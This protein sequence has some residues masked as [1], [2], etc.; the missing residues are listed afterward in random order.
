MKIRI[1]IAAS[2]VLASVA[3]AQEGSY[4][5]RPMSPD[6]PR[7][8]ILP[9]APDG[10][11]YDMDWNTFDGGGGPLGGGLYN[12]NGTV[13]QPDAGLLTGGGFELGGGFWHFEAISCYAN[14]DESTGT[15]LLTANDFQ[16]FL[17]KFAANDPY[18]NCD[19]STG[20][21]L[22]TANDFQCFLNKF[23]AGCS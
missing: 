22:L 3:S 2:G 10:P 21:P 14:C 23:A 4:R 19:G 9:G 17:N 7:P 12:L 13:G 11:G 8:V 18:A 1:I 5:A 6:E 16:C 20:T 15:P